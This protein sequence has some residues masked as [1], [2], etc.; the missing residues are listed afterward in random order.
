MRRIVAEND[1][2]VSS[3]QHREMSSIPKLGVFI[4]SYD[5]VNQVLSNPGGNGTISFLQALAGMSEKH[6]AEQQ[7]QYD[8]MEVS[9][10]LLS[11]NA[12]FK[13][14][15]EEFMQN[16]L[17]TGGKGYT[18]FVTT[19]YQQLADEALQNASN[20]D[21]KQRLALVFNNKKADLSN[22]AV[23]AEKNMY[24]AFVL[25]TTEPK[26]NEVLNNAVKHPSQFDSLSAELMTHLEPL[27]GLV[28]EDEY[29]RIVKDKTQQLVYSV[30]IGQIDNNPELGEKMLEG[31]IFK[32]LPPEAFNRLHK[33]AESSIQAQ[34]RQRKLDE[35]LALNLVSKAQDQRIWNY[36]LAI[37]RGETTAVPDIEKDTMIT[38]LQRTKLLLYAE[39]H[40][41][42][43]DKD[44]ETQ[45]QINKAKES[46]EIVDF[47]K[48]DLD[49]DFLRWKTK[50]NENRLTSSTPELSLTEQIEY[51]KQYPN[52]YHKPISSLNLEISQT[53]RYSSDA[54]KIL[55]ACV[56]IQG[57]EQV[58]SIDLPD[59]DFSFANL[60]VEMF[61]GNQNQ[62]EVKSFRDRFYSSTKEEREARKKEWNSLNISDSENFEDAISDA[63]EKYNI[64]TTKKWYDFS[65]DA[66]L[67]NSPDYVDLHN[68]MANVAKKTFILT[69]SETL[70]VESAVAAGS[71]L[72]KETTVNGS[73]EYMINPPT[74]QNTKFQTSKEIDDF[75]RRKKQKALSVATNADK[76]KK[77]YVGALS[78]SSPVYGFYQLLDENDITSKVWL[79]KSGEVVPRIQIDMRKEVKSGRAR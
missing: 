2:L 37:A 3:K 15:D 28:R 69:G 74:P 27:K 55:D 19:T 47:R 42:R 1:A 51:V 53:L 64:K 54:K 71:N 46:G 4:P 29:L 32:Q 63:F 11:V 79:E 58:E 75:F 50:E 38:D 14:K 43:K 21:V 35:A 39:E 57:N 13:Q 36:K 66:I 33:Y 10:T 22:N 52:V 48:K 41:I 12:K 67:V 70:A 49:D 25:S 16:A 31:E 56:A 44:I 7:T 6:M 5:S 9:D 34:Q 77:V 68:R 40:K 60:A 8:A 17:S 24:S 30:G 76:T 65:S 20:A 73:L 78:V 45:E 18:E 26:I 62:E 23:M 72:V 61:K 59:D